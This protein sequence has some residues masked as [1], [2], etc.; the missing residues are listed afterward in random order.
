MK[1]YTTSA[2][3]T[4]KL[5]I[6]EILSKLE[7]GLNESGKLQ[8]KPTKNTNILKAKMKDGS[9]LAIAGFEKKNGDSL[10]MIDHENVPAEIERETLQKKWK[11]KL[12]EILNN[13]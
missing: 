12:N 9:T 8:F 3:K 11:K 6:E 1:A 7:D 13:K 10:A 4:T 2:Q 5:S